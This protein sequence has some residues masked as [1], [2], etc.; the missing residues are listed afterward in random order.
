MEAVT[1]GGVYRTPKS[2]LIL[3]HVRSEWIK[4]NSR[5][6]WGCGNLSLH[7]QVHN[8]GSHDPKPPMQPLDQRY[9]AKQLW[10]LFHREA[11]PGYFGTKKCVLETASGLWI[12]KQGLKCSLAHKLTSQNCHFIGWALCRQHD[13]IMPRARSFLYKPA[14]KLMT[15][16]ITTWN[17][18]ANH[19]RSSRTTQGF[20]S[21]S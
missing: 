1:M 7:S 9:M 3:S 14:T 6:C 21:R 4:G 17:P 19:T 8:T 11:T 12:T 16:Q 15:I 18:V 5:L 2:S 20:N 10:M 13:V